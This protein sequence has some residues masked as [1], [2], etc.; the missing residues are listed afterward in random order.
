MT[1]EVIHNFCESKLSNNEP[2]EILNSY[3]SLFITIIPI[4]FGFPKNNIFFNIACMFIFN[5]FASFYYHYTLSWSGKQSDEISM[6]MA[7]YFGINGLL[8]IYFINNEPKLNFYS[9]FNNIYSILFIIINT[10]V[11]NDKFFPFLFT[12]HVLFTIFLIHTISK[13]YDYYK[14]LVL[15]KK[16]LAISTCGATCWIISELYCNKYTK[17]GHVIWHLLFPLGFYKLILNFDKLLYNL[18][19]TDI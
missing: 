18:L 10:N 11:S 6:I 2:P 19:I 12:I 13:N 1:T 5:G 16:N 3:T 4:I 14:D 9:L 15:Y 7:T 17:F 8:K